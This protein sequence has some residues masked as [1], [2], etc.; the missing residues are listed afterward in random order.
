MAVRWESLDSSL[1]DYKLN[2][3]ETK[4]SNLTTLKDQLSEF[5]TETTAGL[6]QNESDFTEALAELQARF[7]AAMQKRTRS[8][9]DDFV[10]GVLDEVRR[11][12][13]RPELGVCCRAFE[14]VRKE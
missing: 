2:T 4:V 1:E 14:R 9:L 7:A 11:P 10:R 13:T 6:A 12:R 3:V 8:H 5:V